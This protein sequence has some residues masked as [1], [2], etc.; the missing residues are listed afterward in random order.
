MKEK[1]YKYI[2]E[3]SYPGNIGFEEMAKFY[4]KATDEDISKMEKILKKG[5]WHAFKK[6]I[7]KVLG[8][9]LK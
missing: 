6:L 8:V 3:A 5:D 1:I 2:D 4:R 9:I 7:Q